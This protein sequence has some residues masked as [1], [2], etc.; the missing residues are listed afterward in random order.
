MWRHLPGSLR[1]KS[2]YFDICSLADMKLEENQVSTRGWGGGGGEIS[3][4]E[5]SPFTN[6]HQTL[7]SWNQ[8]KYT[9]NGDSLSDVM[10]E[11]RLGNQLIFAAS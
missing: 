8:M 7:I 1:V 5:Q 4:N 11:R 6:L 10:A 3:K 9:W 2:G